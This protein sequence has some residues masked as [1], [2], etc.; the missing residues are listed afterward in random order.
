[1][2]NLHL[3]DRAAPST[4]T[5]VWR[6]GQRGPDVGM[7]E[8]ISLEQQRFSG[9]L[10]KGV[11]EAVPEVQAGLVAATLPEI[12]VGVPGD[13]SLVVCHRLDLQLSSIDQLVE[14]AAGDRVAARVDHHRGLQVVS[15]G[16]PSDLGPLDGHGHVT[17]IILGAEDCD[18]SG[19][20]DDQVGS[21]RSS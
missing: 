17:G 9:G 2:M 10:R 21:P 4:G 3:R 14:T 7:G 15:G 18:E 8:V 20:V 1:M 13:P 5:V 6:G 11:R 12:T 16:D 19:R